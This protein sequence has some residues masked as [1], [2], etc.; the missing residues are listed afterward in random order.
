[1]INYRPRT[2][3]VLYLSLKEFKRA[4]KSKVDNGTGIINQARQHQQNPQDIIVLDSNQISRTP[5]DNEEYVLGAV[6]TTS[7][8]VQP[9]LQAQRKF[10]QSQPSSPS[11]TPVKVLEASP[12]SPN[13]PLSDLTKCKPKTEDF[14]TFLCLRGSAALPSNMKYFGTAQDDEDADEEEEDEEQRE[15]AAASAPASCH[16]TPRK[17]KAPGR[18]IA[19]GHVFNGQ[20]RATGERESIPRVRGKDGHPAGER[21]SGTPARAST[22]H[23][24]RPSKPALEHKPQVAAGTCWV[25][26]G[27]HQ[28]Y[29]STAK[30]F[31]SGSSA[32]VHAN[33]RRVRKEDLPPSPL[34]KAVKYPKG[35][36][37]YT[38]ARL[39]KEAKLEHIHSGKAQAGHGRAQKQAPA[40]CCPANGRPSGP[41]SAPTRRDGLRQSKRQLETAGA[42]TT[43]PAMEVEVKRVKVQVVPLDTRSRR[44]AQE[45]PAP[46]S[47]SGATEQQVAQCQ[48]PRRAS[49][50]K[51]MFM[52]Q[53]HCMATRRDRSSPTTSPRVSQDKERVRRGAAAEMESQV[54]VFYPGPREF[55]DPLPYVEM[56]RAQAQPFGMF[57]VVPPAGWRPECKLKEEL[58]FVSHVQHVHKL[59]RRWG[60]NV[61]RLACIRKHLR[62]QGIDMEEPPLIGGCELDLARFFQLLNDMGGMQQVTD[63]KTWGRLADLLGIPRSAQDRLAKLQEAYCQYLLSYDSLSP[64]QQARLERE[65]LAEKESLERRSGPLEG[66]TDVSQHAAL[67]LPRCEPKNGLVNGALHRC[68]LREPEPRGGRNRRQEKKGEE[69][70]VLN[71]LHKCMYKG[72]SF[73][74]TTFYRAARNTMNM[75][76]SREPDTAEVE[77]EYWRLVETKQ[78]H[79][80]VHCGRVDTKTHGSGFPVGKSEPFSKHGWNLTVLSNNSGSVLRH[81]GAVPGVTIPWLNIGMVFSTSCWS[82]DQNSL[83][84]IDYL[85]TGADCIWYCIPAE[86]KSKLDKVVHTLLQANGTPG[87]EM[88]EKNIMISPEVLRQEGVK[89]HRTV[90]RS[91][92][93]VVCFPGAFVSKVCCGYSVSETVHFATPEWMTLGYEAAKDLKR[94]RIEEPF[95]TEKLLCKIV[96]SECKQENKHLLSAAS[97]LIVDLRDTEIGQRQQLF[98]AGL[99]LSARYGTQPDNQSAVERKKT[100]RSR[101]TEDTADRRCQVCQHLCYLSMVVH[102]SDNVV[103]CLECA[104]RYIQKR[105]SPRGLK[106]MFRY[107]EEQLNGL[108]NGVCGKALERPGDKRKGASACT[109][110]AKRSSRNRS[111]SQVSLS[112]L[113]N[114]SRS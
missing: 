2:N 48:R 100:P 85:H 88:L 6:H 74:L 114:S 57:A 81:L 34:T 33:S 47:R 46:D 67:L 28:N 82:R 75:C 73:S 37:T 71:E 3:I 72:K 106:M 80:A 26:N 12:S 14:L 38:K 11:A 58:R 27:L 70:G 44:A 32:I 56:V 111:S 42:V 19:N 35:H 83:P 76:F 78:C 84:Y 52:K 60:P 29:L 112:R 108:L 95:S 50:G 77:Q 64:L 13:L 61:Q 62:S 102:E 22:T 24:L 99:R 94:R 30:S 105:R 51:L 41:N 92:Q 55:H 54:P 40:G 36:V 43:E 87:L 17:S 104:L 86:E 16:M 15:T 7:H 65:V 20:T 91:G 66:Q 45:T 107:T 63:M 4:Q 49:A 5:V 53:M 101:L 79:V 109:P 98:K 39:L 113:K 103:F 97:S 69:G 59:G 9:R 10:A 23:N 1:S 8:V 93:F 96:T 18:I 25:K 90:Q 110:P 21:S 68:G 31:V 89:V